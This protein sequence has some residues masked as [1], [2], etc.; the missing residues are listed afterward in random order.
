MNKIALA[1][2]ACL[3]LSACASLTQTVGAL[4][5]VATGAAS[6]GRRRDRYGNVHY[7]WRRYA[8]AI[9]DRILV[10]R[11]VMPLQAEMT[12]DSFG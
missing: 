7:H 5:G 11:V 10:G 4:G 12:A 2:L 3:A 9:P 1:S 6:G 8:N